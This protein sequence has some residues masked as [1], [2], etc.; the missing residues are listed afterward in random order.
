MI[1]HVPP[2]MMYA[3]EEVG[4]EEAAGPADNPR[5]VEYHRAVDD[6]VSDDEVPWCSS[7]VNWCMMRA[8]TERTRSRAARSWLPWGTRLATP[9]YGCV[10]VLW[11]EHPESWKGHVGILVGTAL[12]DVFLLGG[13]QSNEVN[14]RRYPVSRVLG[15]RWPK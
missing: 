8:Q 1:P 14:V 3:W 15:Y 5:I 13:N 6:E 2:W 4:V 12:D 11:R 10:C 7:F 9:A